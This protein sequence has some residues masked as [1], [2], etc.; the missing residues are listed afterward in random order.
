MSISKLAGLWNRCAARS[1]LMTL[2]LTNGVM[3]ATGDI[4]AQCI[5]PHFQ[6]SSSTPDGSKDKPAYDPWRTFRFFAYGCIFG[7]VAFKWYSLL[8]RRFPLPILLAAGKPNRAHSAAKALAVGKR[9]AADQVVFAPV[10]IATF[11]AV[12]GTMEGKSV[13]EVRS[14]LRDRYPQ[15]LAGNYVLWPAAQLINFGLVPL[16]YRV[17]FSS[18]VSIVWN[19]YLSIVNGRKPED[20]VEPSHGT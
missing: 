6:A 9:M 16:I 15:A 10:A 3:G 14:S 4:V 12:M 2:S 1:P 11:F 19:T 17:P 20:R 5:V 13:D 18:L 8:D 7:P